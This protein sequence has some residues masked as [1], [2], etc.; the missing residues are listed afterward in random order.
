M[1]IPAMDISINVQLI[2]VVLV[3]IIIGFGVYPQP[4]IDLTKETIN[5]ILEN[6]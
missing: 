3:I 1:L 5:T 6:K 2:L 4:M